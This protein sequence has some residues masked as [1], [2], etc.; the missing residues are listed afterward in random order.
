VSAQRPVRID[1]RQVWRERATGRLVVIAAV[2]ARVVSVLDPARGEE[3]AIA[4]PRLRARFDY[5]GLA[6]HEPDPDAPPSAID[7]AT[8]QGL[9]RRPTAW[10]RE[11]AA[12]AEERGVGELARLA[13]QALAL[14]GEIPGTR[15]AGDG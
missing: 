9:E 14:R 15:E 3:A 2:N 8:L 11:L 6:L 4:T 12:A 7:A 1:R 10:L 13:R 5:T